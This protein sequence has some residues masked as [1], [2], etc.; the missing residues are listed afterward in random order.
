MKCTVEGSAAVG[1]LHKEIG[2]TFEESFY[3]DPDAHYQKVCEIQDYLAVTYP[4]Y[5]INFFESNLVQTEHWKRDQIVVGGIQPNMIFGVGVGAKFVIPGDKDPDIEV[6][7][8]KDLD[9]NGL[10][11][12]KETDWENTHPINFF[13]NQIDEMKEKYGDSRPIVPP[14]FWDPS[15]RASIHGVITTAQKFMGERVF[16]EMVDNE[17]FVHDFLEWISDTYITLC[18]LFADK[19]GMKITNVHVGECSACLLGPE[20][21]EEFAVPHTQRIIDALGPGRIHSCGLSNHLIKPIAKFKNITCLNT[22]SF[23][24]VE[25]IREEC[26]DELKVEVAPDAKMFCFGTPEE[27]ENWI[28]QTLKEN[29]GAPLGFVYHMDQGYPKNNFVAMHEK[30]IDAGVTE[31]G[32]IHKSCPVSG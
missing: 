27:M 11:R 21:F 22:G 6:T 10:K 23:T 29:G 16:L 12:L 26:G 15:G 13:M 3:Y 19:V 24:S 9:E 5:E 1:W 18:T 28:D 25:Q 4:D 17:K 20:Q 2:L 8:L 7:P 14:F 30:L 31:R 32:R